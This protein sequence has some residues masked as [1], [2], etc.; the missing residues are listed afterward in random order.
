MKG[1]GVFATGFLVVFYT[2]DILYFNNDRM[3]D[4]CV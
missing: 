3:E 4:C 1:G 2:V